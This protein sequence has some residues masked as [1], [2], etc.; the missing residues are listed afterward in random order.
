MEQMKITRVTK[1]NEL[2]FNYMFPREAQGPAPNLIRLGV[3]N[4]EDKG[5]GTLSALVDGKEV[6]I[7]SL[8]ILSDY[9]RQG[10]GRALFEWLQDF[11][12]DQGIEILN[13]EFLS[14]EPA[15]AF[16]EAMGFDLFEL[17]PL[18]TFLL[19]E[20]F[21]S[22]LYKK[23]IDGK[24]VLRVKPV[25]ELS[26]QERKIFEQNII[27][28]GFD[29]GWST[30]VIENGEYSSCLLTTHGK[31]DV[32]F[33]FIN[34]KSGDPREILYH[35]RALVF[36]TMEEFPDRRDIEFRLTVVDDRRIKRLAGILGGWRHVHISG[37][38][39]HA[40]KMM[41]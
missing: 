11:L 18:Y 22:P 41:R 12:K 20:V 29:P 36:K 16:A 6:V 38:F 21:R 34:S 5:V 35:F 24:K 15:E 10:Y 31:Q 33:V 40:V 30:A 19:G 25:S 8:F 13:V 39:R 32:S 9:R 2:K 14:N 37:Y 27:G 26:L 4:D 28:R 23:H 17:R 3:I 7:T 1:E